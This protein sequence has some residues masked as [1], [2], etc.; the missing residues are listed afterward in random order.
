M[1]ALLGS[2]VPTL[3]IYELTVKTLTN[4]RTDRLYHNGIELKFIYALLYLGCGLGLLC[5]INSVILW[6]LS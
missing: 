3:L 5:Q 4:N 1:P 6:T 2:Y